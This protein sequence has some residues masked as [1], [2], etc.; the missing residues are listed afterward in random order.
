MDRIN[1]LSIYETN[2]LY[3]ALALVFIFLGGLTQSINLFFGIVVTEVFIL[4][5]PNIW[6]VKKNN[7]SLKKT[8][9]LNKLSF[10]N[11]L[12]IIVITI[13]TYP[14]AV[15]F[16]AIFVGLVSMVK[17]LQND[18]L[19]IEISQIG[20][21]WSVLFISI[22]PGICE[23]IVFRGTIL[24]AYE[25]LGI[26]KA[27][28]VSALLFGLFHFALINFVGPVILGI[29]FGVMVYKTNSLYS[30]IIGHSLNNFIALTLNYFL[31]ENLELIEDVASNEADVDL[32]QSIISFAFLG[33]IVFL[34]IKIVKSLLNRLT[35][36]KEIL[37][38]LNEEEIYES[39]Y[40]GEYL[41]E[42]KRNNNF[43]IYGP[44]IVVVMIFFIFNFL[45]V[46][47]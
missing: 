45:F 31:M 44:I 14:I 30:S 23:E 46:F 20:F 13:L 22:I 4:V 21:F 6:F 43:L 16:Q 47:V 32:V 1:K 40:L 27:I 12:L 29:V 34:L 18:G 15:F 8:W 35:P 17:P 41:K 38:E 42:E 37:E 19:P 36:H 2:L 28:I 9:R 26:K 25:K 5:V 7:L 39:E 3:L 11:I 24:K 10:K 33:L